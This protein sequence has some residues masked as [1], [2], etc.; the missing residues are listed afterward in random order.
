MQDRV[1]Y[2]IYVND[3][4]PFRMSDKPHREARDSINCLDEI[5]VGQQVIIICG[6]RVKPHDLWTGTVYKKYKSKSLSIYQKDR[7]GQ[8]KGRKFKAQWREVISDTPSK[9][10]RTNQQLVIT[11]IS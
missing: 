3:P 7:K 4:D 9:R 11:R 6:A 2:D 1:P 5:L 8:A 10:L